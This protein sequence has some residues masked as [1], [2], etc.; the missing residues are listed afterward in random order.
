MHELGLVNYV[1]K[2]VSK[3][4]EENNVSKISSVT[5]EFGEVSGIVSSYLYDYWDWYT[6]KYPLFEGSK[7]K[8]EEIPAVTWCDN[9]KITYSTVQYGKTCPHCGSGKTWLL[10]GNE[11]MIKEIEVEDAD[12]P[13]G[14]V[15]EITASGEYKPQ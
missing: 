1:V 2:E 8:C 9:C 6:K 12:M 3:I 14:T 7:L 10:R 4:A 13:E 5:L 15:G 11:M